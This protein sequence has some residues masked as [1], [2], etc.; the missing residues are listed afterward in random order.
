[1]AIWVWWDV[2]SRSAWLTWSTPHEPCERFLICC[3]LCQLTEIELVP[4]RWRHNER[5]GVSNHQPHD[6]LLR[7]SGADQ[8]KHQSSASL[9]FV[10]GINRWTVNSL[11]KWPVTR[12]MFPF[13][14]V[15]MHI[16]LGHFTGTAGGNHK[17]TPVPPHMIISLALRRSYD[18]SR[19]NE[20]TTRNISKEITQKSIAI[21]SS[22]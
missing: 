17:I 11:H 20:A 6:C 14:D 22:M 19:E 4:L 21:L 1:M 18:Y 13:D 10:R 8:I 9:A 15:N 7:R 5:D 2:N 12:K 3:A 16:P